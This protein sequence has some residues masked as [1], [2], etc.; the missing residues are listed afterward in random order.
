VE[1]IVKNE[2]PSGDVDEK[3]EGEVSGVRDQV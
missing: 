2:G 3:K 1:K